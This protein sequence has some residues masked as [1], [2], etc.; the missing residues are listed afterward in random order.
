MI[1]DDWSKGIEAWEKV[2]KQAQIDIE[3]AD[4]YISAIK[5]QILKNDEAMKIEI[6]NHYRDLK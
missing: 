6:D 4:L 3:Q 2:K 1:T 5:K